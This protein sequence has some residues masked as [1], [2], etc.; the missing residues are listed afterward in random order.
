[1]PMRADELFLAVLFPVLIAVGI[2]MGV[3]STSTIEFGIA[4]ASFWLAAS[5]PVVLAFWAFRN[6]DLSVGSL[7]ALVSTVGITAGALGLG[8]KWIDLKEN[9]FCLVMPTYEYG[10]DP[11][12]GPYQLVL[13]NSGP[14]PAL[15]VRIHIREI[16]QPN[17]DVFKYIE[18]GDVEAESVRSLDN[19]QPLPSGSYQIDFR[20]RSG[21]FQEL[22]TFQKMSDRLSIKYVIYRLSIEGNEI[23]KT[24][25]KEQMQ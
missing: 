5:I 2:A 23:K 3:D 4:R 12:P 11:G 9:T 8:L 17:D 18:L 13:F 21:A 6:I 1:M 7:F 24:I 25:V 19:L 14:F 16:H 22:L 10:K 20:Q 15:N